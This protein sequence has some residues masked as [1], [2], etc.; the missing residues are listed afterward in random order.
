MNK[1]QKT[2]QS[3]L[4]RLKSVLDSDVIKNKLAKIVNDNPETFATSIIQIASQNEMLMNAEPN[5]IIAA[6]I[7]STTLNL[8]LN[9]SLGQAY[10]VPFNEKQKDGSYMVKAQ[11]ILGY[12]GIRQLATRSG[13]FKFMNTT[14]VRQGEIIFMDRLSG[15]IE[16]NWEQDEKIREKLP[17]VGYVSYFKLLNGFESFYYMT[18][19]DIEKHAKKFSQT[20]KKGFGNWVDEKDKMSRKTVCKLHLNG[21]E[22]PLSI[23]MQKA[24]KSDQAVLD[25]DDEG[26]VL[27]VEN[28]PDNEVP[29]VDPELERIREYIENIERQEEADLIR[30]QV[31]DELQDLF[32]EKITEKGLR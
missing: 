6:A 13:N 8:P 30:K 21:G 15:E 12:K 16:F 14:D 11:F 3:G 24:I 2:E 19:A 27:E 25:L 5:S 23:S 20:Y 17:I 18:V 1:V 32:I 31:P 28:Y 10:I 29:S 4:S 26:N 22:A 9:N 7:T